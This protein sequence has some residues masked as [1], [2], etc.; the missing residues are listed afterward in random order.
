MLWVLRLGVRWT[1]I[2][3]MDGGRRRGGGGGL[4]LACARAAALLACLLACLRALRAPG[5][6][7]RTGSGAADG[8]CGTDGRD[9]SLAW[10]APADRGGGLLVGSCGPVT[11]PCQ[12]GG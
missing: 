12:T 5:K 7:A 9:A 6:R 8:R 1:G 4:P 2:R 3:A 10:P 11:V